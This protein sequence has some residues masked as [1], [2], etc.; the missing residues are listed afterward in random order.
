MSRVMLVTGGCRS[1]K[2]A[3]ALRCALCYAHRTY[4][5]S[6][7]AMDEEMRDRISRHR[8]DRGDAFTT[9]E[10]PLDLAGALSRIPPGGSVA[11][12]DCLTIWLSNLMHEHGSG[13]EYP[14]MAAFL[15]ALENSPCDVIMVTNEV[16]MGIVPAEPMTRAYRDLAGW[17]NQDVARIANTV[18]FVVCGQ[19]LI[20]KGDAW[21][22]AAG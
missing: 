10:A 17:L 2:S 9:V 5:A 11:L 18:A 12:I 13:G 8:K 7:T 21:E 15:C 4:V 3:Y 14:E 1:G 20:A 19:P 16:G 22:E 6:A